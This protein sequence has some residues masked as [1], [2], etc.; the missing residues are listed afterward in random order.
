[1]QLW[2]SVNNVQKQIW[3]TLCLVLLT[4]FLSAVQGFAE[5]KSKLVTVWM[6][7]IAFWYLLML[8]IFHTGGRAK[9]KEM[10]MATLLHQLMNSP[11]QQTPS[12]SGNIFIKLWWLWFFTNDI[13][14][15]LFSKCLLAFYLYSEKI[16][17][18]SWLL[19]L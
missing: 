10:L 14:N 8:A 4:W 9:Q 2:L 1:M 18:F 6:R 15:I 12:N 13:F 3:W 11:L 5:H 7:Q 19:K 16:L 17:G